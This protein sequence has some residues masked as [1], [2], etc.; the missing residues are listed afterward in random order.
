[1]TNFDERSTRW[2]LRDKGIPLG[3]SHVVHDSGRLPPADH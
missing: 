1:M 2:F 3:R